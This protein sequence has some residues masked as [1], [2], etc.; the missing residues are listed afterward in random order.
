[1]AW[2]KF[3]D[4]LPSNRKWRRLVK[5][6]PEAACLWVA[7]TCYSARYLTD[8]RIPKDEIDEVGPFRK[9]EK[10]AALLVE[11]RMFEDD[12]DAWVVH[13]YLDHN[14]NA[15]SVI[16]KREADRERQ[17]RQR[18]KGASVV[19]RSDSGQFVAPES[20]RDT[21]RDS[22]RESEE[23]SPATRPVP[24]RPRRSKAKEPA[25]P[26]PPDPASVILR[27]FHDHADPKPAQPWPAML[28]VVRK[29]LSAGWSEPEV[30]WALRDAPTVSAGALTFS[31]NR[32]GGPS[33]GNGR[34]M[35]LEAVHE[36][37]RQEGLLG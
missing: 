24:S 20:Q 33:N 28:G 35:G 26:A 3:D 10:L 11:E 31:L 22:H 14:P 1:M 16:A 9:P 6:S 19:G 25:V 7:S 18:K 21:E 12:G 17:E 36:Y 37:A 32:R 4:G 5:R 23:A 2:A 8:G 29:M 34:P 27:D 30:A 15:A 13:D